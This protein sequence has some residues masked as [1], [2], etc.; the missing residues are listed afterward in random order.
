[1]Q[2]YE[3]KRYEFKKSYTIEAGTIPEGTEVMLFRGW[4]YI[5]GAMADD[6]SNGLIKSII[7]NPAK[8]KEYLISL[9]P[10]GY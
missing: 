2:Q 7:N 4:A 9:P 6:Y 3:Q 8:C 10:I 5:N 1:M